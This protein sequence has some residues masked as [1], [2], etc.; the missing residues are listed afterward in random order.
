M[1]VSVSDGTTALI[2]GA[3]V[4]ETL[5]LQ[6]LHAEDGIVRFITKIVQSSL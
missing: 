4:K 6:Q 1:Y 2:P 3:H 5:L